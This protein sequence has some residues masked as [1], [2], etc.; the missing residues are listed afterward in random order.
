MYNNTTRIMSAMNELFKACSEQLQPTIILDEHV[1]TPAVG[2]D[3]MLKLI[4]NN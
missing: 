1:I 3:V 2:D 4:R